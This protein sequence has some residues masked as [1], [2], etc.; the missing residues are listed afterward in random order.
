MG[1]WVSPFKKMGAAKLGEDKRK[2]L[3]IVRVF[4]LGRDTNYSL[5]KVKLLSQTKFAIFGNYF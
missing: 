4:R 3:V 5:E 2:H 1:D